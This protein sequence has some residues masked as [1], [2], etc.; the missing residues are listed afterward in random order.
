VIATKKALGSIRVID[1][2]K[3]YKPGH[4]VEADDVRAL[5]GVMQGDRASKGFVTTTSDFAPR[6][7]DDPFIAEFIPAR[8]ELINGEKLLANLKALATRR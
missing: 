3:A 5:W 4:L 1:S 8:L 6:I 2:V 7:K